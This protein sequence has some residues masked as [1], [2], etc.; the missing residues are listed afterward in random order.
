[1]V[2]R[3]PGT[4]GA[5]AVSR[6]EPDPLNRRKLQ[7]PSSSDKRGKA[8]NKDPSAPRLAFSSILMC[9][10]LPTSHCAV[11]PRPVRPRRT[12]QLEL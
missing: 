9:E 10:P 5:P 2:G 8:P 1:V 4:S 7:G 6:A 12:P 3:R 11:A